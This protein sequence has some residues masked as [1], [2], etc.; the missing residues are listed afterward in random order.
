MREGPTRLVWKT[1]VQHLSAEPLVSEQVLVDAHTGEAPFHCSL[2]F[3]D[4][5]RIIYDKDG[6]RSTDDWGDERRSEGQSATGKID[7]VNLAYELFGDI[8]DQM[9][10]W[11]GRDSYNG[12]GAAMEVSVRWGYSD[13]ALTLA[14][15]FVPVRKADTRTISYG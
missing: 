8:Y 7:P 15:T 13:E 9:D 12:Y 5:E 4:K 11:H 14:G 3:R 1:V 6:D 2:L 10:L